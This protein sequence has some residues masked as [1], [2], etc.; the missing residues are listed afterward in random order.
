MLNKAGSAGSPQAA[1]QLTLEE[2]R[3]EKTHERLVQ[4]GVL[5]AA[6]AFAADMKP[7]ADRIQAI[8]DIEDPDQFTDEV[9]KLRDELPALLEKIGKDPTLADTL[10][11]IFTAALFN[12]MAE[13]PLQGAAHTTAHVPTGGDA[14]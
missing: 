7:L 9:K 10:E 5:D 11:G 14:E 4:A 1:P 8:I 13:A 3:A 6:G 12:G 2:A